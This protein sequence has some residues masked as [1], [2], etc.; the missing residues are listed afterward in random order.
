MSLRKSLLNFT[1]L[2]NTGYSPKDFP[3]L[4]CIMIDLYNP[5]IAIAAS[6]IFLW[7]ILSFEERT[8]RYQIKKISFAILLSILGLCVSTMHSSVAMTGGR[9]WYF[10]PFFT[11]GW[12]DAMAY[13]AGVAFGKH[14]LIGLSPNKTLEGFIGALVFNFTTTVLL[15][16]RVL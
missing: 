16:D 6:L 1:Y 4:K 11:T 7:T 9:W 2:E 13:F 3:L 10:F 14:K 15:T 12:N 8:V 5:L